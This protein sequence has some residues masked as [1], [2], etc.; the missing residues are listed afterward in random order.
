M[1]AWA[2]LPAAGRG[3][4]SA[5][6][7][8]P[9][10]PGGRIAGVRLPQ[11]VAHGPHRIRTLAG[12][13]L[14]TRDGPPVR[15][16][17]RDT[18]QAPTLAGACLGGK[19]GV[20][21]NWQTQ[22]RQSVGSLKA[23]FRLSRKGTNWGQW[24][25]GAHQRVTLADTR[26]SPLSAPSSV[27][28]LTS[29]ARS[30]CWRM[31]RLS[32]CACAVPLA[33]SASRSRK[34][35][36]AACCWWRHS[37]SSAHE[38][39]Q[40]GH[41]TRRQHG[42]DPCFLSACKGMVPRPRAHAPEVHEQGATAGWGHGGTGASPRV[43]RS[44]SV[45]RLSS[46]ACK[47]CTD[48]QR[49]RGRRPARTARRPALRPEGA[50]A[51][52]GRAWVVRSGLTSSLL[53]LSA[54][55]AAAASSRCLRSSSRAVMR[56]WEKAACT[57]A[58]GGHAACEASLQLGQGCGRAAAQA[59]A[60]TACS[61]MRGVHHDDG[62]L[63]AE[64]DAHLVA[65]LCLQCGQLG[66]QQLRLLVGQEHCPEHL[67][68]AHPHARS[69]KMAA[70]HRD[71]RA[72]KAPRTCSQNEACWLRRC[73]LTPLTWW[74]VLTSFVGCPMVPLPFLHGKYQVSITVCRDGV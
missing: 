49:V 51:C 8:R 62:W 35:R 74:G 47:S 44:S 57:T 37:S 59:A 66:Q 41:R 10:R 19:E 73:Y 27:L 23:E 43:V 22:R 29:R 38:A 68:T 58:Q 24:Q 39:G 15:T 5:V 34:P 4:V 14:H 52:G 36:S 70:G 33:C 32:R 54:A 65:E 71:D 3:V 26:P 67:H 1:S 45:H 20:S 9:R 61:P 28:A 55:C 11:D 18:S 50:A 12:Q 72:R 53:L 6:V 30:S 64:A 46:W 42:S 69:R 16:A 56:S 60:A 2:D 17:H 48:T 13:E 25:P 7:G 40:G 31:Q 21:Y 63:P